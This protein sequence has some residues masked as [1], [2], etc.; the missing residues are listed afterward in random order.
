MMKITFAN[1]FTYISLH[2]VQG[3]A[4]VGLQLWL[5]K[6]EFILVLLF[7]N[8]CIIFHKNNYKLTFVP[9]Y[10]EMHTYT[11]IQ[12]NWRYVFRDI[13]EDTYVCI[14]TYEHI[15][16]HTCLCEEAM[17][18]GGL[19]TK[20]LHLSYFYFLSFFTFPYNPWL[21]YIPGIILSEMLS[22]LK[23]VYLLINQMGNLAL[24]FVVRINDKVFRW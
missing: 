17:I 8:Y 20:N 13:Y 7:I 19:E 15:H 12:Y 18:Q 24:G 4:K 1:I 11:H 3:G 16:I 6:T 2:V 21:S 9:T 5:S 10:I 23:C 22:F 14:Y